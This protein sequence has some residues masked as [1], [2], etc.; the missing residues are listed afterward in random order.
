MRKNKIKYDKMLYDMNTNEDINETHLNQKPDILTI[1][2]LKN[3]LR[4]GISTIE[5]H[6]LLAPRRRYWIEYLC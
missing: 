2:Y 4:K 3:K 6:I 1:I 5:T